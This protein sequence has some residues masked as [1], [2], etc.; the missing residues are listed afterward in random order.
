M[1]APWDFNNL[2]WKPPDGHCCSIGMASSLTLTFKKNHQR[3]QGPLWSHFFWIWMEKKQ[4]CLIDSPKT[5]FMPFQNNHQF[6]MAPH[7]HDRTRHGALPQGV[8]SSL[9]GPTISSATSQCG[10]WCSI[11]SYISMIPKTQSFLRNPYDSYIYITD[12]YWSVWDVLWPSSFK[13]PID[14]IASK[15]GKKGDLQ[16]SSSNLAVQIK[17]VIHKLRFAVCI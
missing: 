14:L 15:A 6:F 7:P 10:G 17:S 3:S 16:I 1:Q 13:S 11:S 2:T 12:Y 8:P 4:S 5:H 9:S